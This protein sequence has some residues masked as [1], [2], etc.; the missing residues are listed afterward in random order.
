MD[1]K[2]SVC[3]R[4]H[5]AICP[6]AGSLFRPSLSLPYRICAMP[7]FLAVRRLTPNFWPNQCSYTSTTKPQRRVLDHALHAEI[8]A[9]PRMVYSGAVFLP[10]ACLL[11]VFP[12]GAKKKSRLTNIT[13]P[14]VKQRRKGLRIFI[15]VGNN[16]LFLLYRLQ[17]W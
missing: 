5:A 17:P 3:E 13:G 9:P 11:C 16:F 8:S 10:P 2:S 14:I 1:Q 6:S 15:F 7:R 4:N 12:N